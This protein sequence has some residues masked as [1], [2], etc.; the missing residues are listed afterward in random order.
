MPA[1]SKSAQ[2][3]PARKSGS[4][5]SER[6]PASRRSGARKSAK[7]NPA[8]VSADDSEEQAEESSAED[9]HAYQDDGVQEDDEDDELSL[10][11]DALDED[12]D[13]QA[14]R[15]P[16]KRKRS[17]QSRS[18]VKFKQTV[19]KKRKNKA[20]S[21]EDDDNDAL[22][23]KEGQ[24]VV[25]TVVQ[26]PKTG[27]VPA[28]QISR[29]T[30]DFLTQLKNPE[31][32]DREW[33]KLHEPVYRLAE[34]EWKDFVDEFTNVLVEID[35]QI[36]HLPPKD[37]IH[38]IYR[39]CIVSFKSEWSS[40]GDTW[41]LVSLPYSAIK[42]G[43]QSLIAAGSWCPGKNEL[44]TIRNNLLRS[45]TRF[46]RLISAPEFVRYFGEPK[47]RPDGDRQNI[48]G[49]ED[50]LKVAPKG[51]EKTHKDIDILK[52]RSFAVL[53]RF[54]DSEV[55]APDFKETLGKV[56]RVV[57]PFV[58]CLNDLMTLQDAGNSDSDD[59][60]GEDEDADDD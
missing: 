26:A 23:L 22:N 59:E 54:M 52:C 8:T 35:S 4:T 15:R 39:D 56:V 27:R 2:L 50:E 33:F 6:K 44:A 17:A 30:F 57:R 41:G 29:N 53:H 24:E 21:E 55:L 42:P 40:D 45:S 28:G 58:H 11:S 32:N 16:N 36:P 38:R 12:S 60:H 48:F 51:V 31:C 14:K 13:D 47:P 9:E 37:V 20:E 49:G 10:H 19:N 18:P 25:G 46:R 7:L 5:K 34:K 1:R 3:T 43:G